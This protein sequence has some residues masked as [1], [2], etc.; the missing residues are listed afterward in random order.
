ML[1]PLLEMARDARLRRLIPDALR[2]SSV[3]KIKEGHIASSTLA[4]EWKSFDIGSIPVM[5]NMDCA[6][7]RLLLAYFC[8]VNRNP[9][10]SS[11]GPLCLCERS[12]SPP[13]VAPGNKAAVECPLP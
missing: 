3:G 2:G 12:D 6:G 13:P 9:A 4:G 5:D 7:E 10:R 11:P 8:S 1:P